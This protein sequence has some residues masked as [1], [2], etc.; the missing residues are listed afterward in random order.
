MICSSDHPNRS[1]C[2]AKP[3]LPLCA[4]LMLEYLSWSGLPDIEVRVAPPM[5]SLNLGVGFKHSNC[6]L[7]VDLENHGGDQMYE[8]TAE[9][10][11]RHRRLRRRRDMGTG[12]VIT[13]AAFHPAPH[14]L[15]L[16]QSTSRNSSR[17]VERATAQ[18]VVE[19]GQIQTRR[20]IGA[21]NRQR[22]FFSCPAKCRSIVRRCTATPN[23]C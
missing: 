11:L 6:S 2:W 1:A 15:A 20:Y 10:N 13:K 8:L 21:G 4:F 19:S 12:P 17:A 14:T 16:K 22:S 9:R 3:I 23:R 7:L 18:L 5:F